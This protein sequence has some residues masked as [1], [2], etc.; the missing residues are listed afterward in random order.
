MSCLNRDE[1][2]KAKNELNFAY[3]KYNSADD[4]F[5]DSAIYEIQTK[6]D[7]YNELLKIYKTTCSTGCTCKDSNL[8][9]DFYSR[10]LSMFSKVSTF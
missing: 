8:S 2:F 10:I 9:K 4:K 5:I 1:L 7:R 3:L 6:Q